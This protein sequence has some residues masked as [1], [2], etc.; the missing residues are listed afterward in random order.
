MAN[1]LLRAPASFGRG[2]SSLSSDRPRGASAAR[3]LQLA[4]SEPGDPMRN[5][6]GQPPPVSPE[7]DFLR[8]I[9]DSAVAACEL[10]TASER[11]VLLGIKSDVLA[12]WT[13]AMLRQDLAT[14]SELVVIA[15]LVGNALRTTE[16]NP[17]NSGSRSMQPTKPTAHGSLE[18]KPITMVG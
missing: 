9:V 15:H 13:S 7:A 17:Y 1:I 18:T 12:R 14:V 8:V 11:D 4:T 10:A 2:S 6:P 5:D 16:A 3:T